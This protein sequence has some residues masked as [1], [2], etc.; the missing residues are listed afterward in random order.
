MVKV[1]DQTGIFISTCH[2]GLLQTLVEMRKSR[3]L[4]KYALAT[5]NK[6]LDVYRPH[7]ATGYDIGC[8]YSTTVHCFLVNSFH[9]HAHNCHCQ[10]EFHPLYQKG[11]GL[12]DLETCERIF[13]ALNAV[14]PIICH[15]AYFHWLQFID[16]HF[17]QWDQDKYLEL[18]KFLCDNYKQALHIINEFTPTVEELK[19]QLRISDAEFKHWNAEEAEYFENLKREPD[20]DIQSTT[21]I[22]ALQALSVAE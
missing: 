12:E 17:N 5:T 22:E 10:L 1:F 6:I 13:S 19:T 7:G 21:C 2:H 16:L 3:E 9:G 15:A 4:A 14:S 11:L 18:S 20:F 8:L